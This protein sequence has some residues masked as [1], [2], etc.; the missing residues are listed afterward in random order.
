M[1]LSL[2]SFAVVLVVGCVVGWLAAKIVQGTRFGLVADI[3]ISLLGA[4]IGATVVGGPRDALGAAFISSLIGAVLLLLV[5]RW[6][7]RAFRT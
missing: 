7:G 5:V 2:Q 3:A 6:V 1:Y 4:F